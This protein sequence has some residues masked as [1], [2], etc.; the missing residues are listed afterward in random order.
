MENRMKKFEKFDIDELTNFLHKNNQNQSEEVFVNKYLS[1]VISNLKNTP[2]LYRSFGPYWW[3]L[4]RLIIGYSN[5]DG[6]LGDSYD[7]ALDQSFS[8]D[9]DALTVCAAYSMQQA[10]V[11]NGYMYSV[12]HTVYTEDQ[13]QVELVIE[14]GDVERLIFSETFI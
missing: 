2:K 14:D 5:Y 10:T 8:Y 13:E 4:K 7:V 3:P 1:G 9:S 12:S 6:F 11:E